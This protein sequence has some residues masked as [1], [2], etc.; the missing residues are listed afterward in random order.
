MDDQLLLKKLGKETQSKQARLNANRLKAILPNAFLAFDWND[1]TKEL[2]GHLRVDWQV[3]FSNMIQEQKMVKADIAQIEVLKEQAI[4]DV[5]TVVAREKMELV[6][7]VQMVEQ[8]DEQISKLLGMTEELF[9]KYSQGK[10][11]ASALSSHISRISEEMASRAEYMMRIANSY[12]ALSNIL[13]LPPLEELLVIKA[14]DQTLFTELSRMTLPQFSQPPPGDWKDAQNVPKDRMDKVSEFEPVPRRSVSKIAVPAADGKDIEIDLTHYKFSGSARIKEK[15]GQFL[16][17]SDIPATDAHLLNVDDW[18]QYYSEIAKIYKFPD[19]PE[20]LDRFTEIAPLVF[21]QLDGIDDPEDLSNLLSVYIEPVFHRVFPYYRSLL[22]DPDVGLPADRNILKKFG[23]ALMYAMEVKDLKIIRVTD[24]KGNITEKIVNKYF[25]QPGRKLT[26]EERRQDWLKNRMTRDMEMLR[27][28]VAGRRGEA[29]KFPVHEG[30]LRWLSSR[31]TTWDRVVLQFLPVPDAQKYRTDIHRSLNRIFPALPFLSE[32]KDEKLTKFG[33]LLIEGMYRSVTANTMSL[34]MEP[35]N[36][37]AYFAVIEAFVPQ[38]MDF[39]NLTEADVNKLS[40]LPEFELIRLMVNWMF[41]DTKLT[42]GELTKLQHFIK[43]ETEKAKHSVSLATA[44]FWAN[45]FLRDMEIDPR[46]LKVSELDELSGKFSNFMERI[47]RIVDMSEAQ[48]LFR[49]QEQLSDDEPINWL[50]SEGQ[51]FLSAIAIDWLR[52]G[53]DE[54]QVKAHLKNIMY[55]S[56]NLVPEIERYNKLIDRPIDI[57]FTTKD[58]L[59]HRR[60]WGEISGLVRTLERLNDK[61]DIGP[62]MLGSTLDDLILIQTVSQAEGLRIESGQDGYLYKLAYNLIP[63]SPLPE[64]FYT[65]DPNIPHNEALTR[66]IVEIVVAKARYQTA[67]YGSSYY[68]PGLIEYL[69]D[70]KSTGN[71]PVW[72]SIDDINNMLDAVK[73][74]PAK[75]IDK[76]LAD[77][78]VAMSQAVSIVTQYMPSRDYDVKQLLDET[79]DEMFLQAIYMNYHI[80]DNGVPQLLQQGEI[81][82]YLK[83]IGRDAMNRDDV[84]QLFKYDG[85]LKDMEDRLL[86]LMEDEIM[87][88]RSEQSLT[89]KMYNRIT[90]K[91]DMPV[92]PLTDRDRYA[93]KASV[94]MMSKEQRMGAATRM[95]DKME[96]NL[97]GKTHD[98]A[99]KYVDNWIKDAAFVQ[100]LNWHNSNGRFVLPLPILNSAIEIFRESEDNLDLMRYKIKKRFDGIFI[101]DSSY[102]DLGDSDRNLIR[103]IR[104]SYLISFDRLLGT[105]RE[106]WWLDQF[107]ELEWYMKTDGHTNTEIAIAQQEL[108]VRLVSLHQEFKDVV[109]K[110]LYKTENQ[111]NTE[112]LKNTLMYLEHALVDEFITQVTD[113][114]VRQVKI[115]EIRERSLAEDAVVKPV[116]KK[117][118]AERLL[119]MPAIE[120]HLRTSFNRSRMKESL[121]SRTDAHLSAPE[122]EFLL[123][124]MIEL[125]YTQEDVLFRFVELPSRV[126]VIYERV[127][128]KK[129]V[130]QEDWEFVS[131]LSGPVFDKWGFTDV[132]DRQ[133]IAAGLKAT[134]KTPVKSVDEAIDADLVKLEKI[135]VMAEKIEWMLDRAGR[136][137]ENEKRKKSEM[138]R[139]A[140]DAY[141]GAVTLEDLNEWIK[142]AGIIKTEAEALGVEL[143]DKR[144]YFI[145]DLL[146]RLGIAELFEEPSVKGKEKIQLKT[147]LIGMLDENVFKIQKEP[148]WTHRAISVAPDW[149]ENMIPE[150]V[151]TFL[152]DSSLES[153]LKY[154][155]QDPVRRTKIIQKITDVMAKRGMDTADLKDL[156]EKVEGQ[157][158]FLELFRQEWPKLK[159]IDDDEIFGELA[160]LTNLEIMLY[161]DMTRS[162]SIKRI[163]LL[164]I[165]FKDVKIGK[166]PIDDIEAEDIARFHIKVK[167]IMDLATMKIEAARTDEIDPLEPKPNWHRMF[168]GPLTDKEPILDKVFD[169]ER[170]ER[171]AVQQPDLPAWMKWL[172]GTGS[173]IERIVFFAFAFHLMTHLYRVIFKGFLKDPLKKHLGKK[174]ARKL[175]PYKLM[176]FNML[177]FNFITSVLTTVLILTNLVV[178]N[179]YPEAIYWFAVIPF[180]TLTRILVKLFPRL[181]VLQFITQFPGMVYLG[182]F[183]AGFMVLKYGFA[184]HP[185]IFCF[186]LIS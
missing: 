66:M 156:F 149:I 183:G 54:A 68:K 127:T 62:A 171:A 50:N 166:V 87:A 21:E 118:E 34:G 160:H 74:A 185:D 164:D 108:L 78:E 19:D 117:I 40:E 112:N 165:F 77:R 129:V 177:L 111:V 172:M 45:Q 94:P 58:K 144:A 169:R 143:S 39:V 32:V 67:S 178:F 109:D 174:L 142:V 176:R 13:K 170:E 56:G 168:T 9:L 155:L 104:F 110:H 72:M 53:W 61:V 71:F 84:A 162:D 137:Y 38:V 107:R 52:E 25:E 138:M 141:D 180:L 105:D 133:Q 17:E 148:P 114:K 22:F 150:S 134:N 90:G 161:Y 59:L 43:I 128:G 152:D 93:I 147:D 8:K 100:G 132:S 76:G 182:I 115:K 145:A 4:Y 73:G 173:A 75:G 163:G 24:E 29:I 3:W 88:L 157:Q 37:D 12:D 41:N 14:G 10:I 79:F 36:I 124:K 18:A 27:I 70:L 47:K 15:I 122:L 181:N 135:L 91:D 153:Y 89:R 146:L 126:R 184:A 63:E 151:I 48:E 101:K 1:M 113:F 175:N 159:R 20:I 69:N 86:G 102:R 186:Y 28:G 49:M 42:P 136:I 96:L 119:R 46:V 125:G 35:E 7:E 55:T 97:I 158:Q 116:L 80:D 123:N 44:M 140:A 65:L 26:S 154:Q 2:E 103:L 121:A 130:T 23:L 99:V 106:I 120:E 31:A 33:N 95:K 60:I 64:G 57:D 5:K 81:G 11:Q 30:Y 83:L 16:S 167:K 92:K 98:D 131:G 82:S 85:M 139:I 179:P 6:E 51:G